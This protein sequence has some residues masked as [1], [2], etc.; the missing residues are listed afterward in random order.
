MR[1]SFLFAAFFSLTFKFAFGQTYT[2]QSTIGGIGEKGKKII[3]DS[4][5]YQLKGSSI[6]FLETNVGKTIVE[7]D[8][9]GII[10]NKYTFPVFSNAKGN[11]ALKSINEFYV[12][13]EDR[14]L[15]YQDDDRIIYCFKKSGEK[16]YETKSINTYLP[17]T[18]EVSFMSD[19]KNNL[20]VGGAN[21]ISVLDKNGFFLKNIGKKG[22][23]NGEFNGQIEQLFIDKQDNVYALSQGIIQVF[24]SSGKFLYKFEI[25]YSEKLAFD[26]NNFYACSTNY[27]S[28]ET[29]DKT[30][31]VKS[32][33][34]IGNSSNKIYDVV[35]F[36]DGNVIIVKNKYS[37]SEYTVFDSAG[38]SLRKLNLDP[39]SE[40]ID[41]LND[42]VF[43]KKGNLYV[44]D[45]YKI[46]SYD[47]SLKNQSTF[48]EK[49]P[50]D[51]TDINQ[52][53]SINDKRDILFF[54]NSNY[55]LNTSNLNDQLTP[56]KV[57][58]LDGKNSS[59]YIEIDS[60]KKEIKFLVSPFSGESYINVYDFNSKF[61]RKYGAYKKIMAIAKT[62]SNLY[63]LITSID[64]DYKYTIKV[65][66]NDGLEVASYKTEIG[67]FGD[68]V[69]G[70]TFD[71]NEILHIG[72]RH[73]YNG[74]G[75]SVY[76]FDSK[77]KFLKSLTNLSD[78]GGNFSSNGMAKVS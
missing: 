44:A 32:K 14:I 62:K 6:F 31:V 28:L 74:N 15:A 71:E 17:N 64:F 55:G 49:G 9:E 75:Y 48:F 37:G 56:V 30:G 77:G 45:W 23:A 34:A 16:V 69:V 57:N 59:N 2:L 53:L 51:F 70:A 18:S 54:S 35:G 1:F 27:T 76:A 66:N 39:Y 68:S 50:I 40:G 19:S 52:I 26:G 58:A 13:S 47:A 12:D 36:I 67:D 63:Y 3:T 41:A 42:F 20:Y 61:L 46:Q 5:K 43:D 25:P 10:V 78:N 33:L 22:T 73:V 11:D 24:D 60:L 29:L 4:R 38:K 65:L 21:N 8:K 72:V 7:I